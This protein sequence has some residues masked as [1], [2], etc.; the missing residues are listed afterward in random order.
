[1][2]FDCDNF[3]RQSLYA[4]MDTL[5]ELREDHNPALRLEG[6]VVN[7]FQPNAKLPRRLIEEL[8]AEGLPVVPEHLNASVKMRESHDAHLPL[9]H[10]APQH[11]LTQQFVTLFDA[12]E[13]PAQARRRVSARA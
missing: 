4:V 13:E 10:L 9:V 7:Q 3:S 2:P 11:K 12:L 8:E 6:I 5:T 1:M